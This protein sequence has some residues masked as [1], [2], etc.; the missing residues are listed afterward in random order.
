MSNLLTVSGLQSFYGVSQILHGLDFTVKRGE[1]VALLGRN[2]PVGIVSAA[3]LFGF[4]DSTSAE[5]QLSGVPSSIV[6]V[7]QAIIV[8]V[9]VIVNEASSRWLNRRT[10]ERAAIALKD[11]ASVS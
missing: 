5:L 7:I 1:Q 6:K 11:M 4:L 3:L 8:L 2:H 9:V 10:A